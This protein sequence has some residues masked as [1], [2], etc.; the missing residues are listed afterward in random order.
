MLEVAHAGERNEVDLVPGLH[1]RSVVRAAEL[2][3]DGLV[4]LAVNEQLRD[5]ER[6]QLGRRSLRE[7]LRRQQ[8]VD[9]PAGESEPR[10]LRVVA[11]AGLRDGPGDEP[12]RSRPEREVPARRVPDC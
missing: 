2:D 8:L 11:H 1:G 12:V 7:G 9:D 3:R 10:D 6:K 4:G 5:A